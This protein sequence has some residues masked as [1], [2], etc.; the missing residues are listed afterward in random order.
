MVNVVYHISRDSEFNWVALYQK[1]GL[2]FKGES[3]NQPFL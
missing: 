2:W 3:V 1:A